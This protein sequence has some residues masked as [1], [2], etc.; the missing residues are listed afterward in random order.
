VSWQVAGTGSAPTTATDFVGQSPLSGVLT[1]VPGQ[2]LT[3]LSIEVAGDNE[4]EW[5]LYLFDIKMEAGK[6]FVD[7]RSVYYNNTLVAVADTVLE[8]NNTILRDVGSGFN[9]LLVKGLDSTKSA[10]S[11]TYTY[12]TFDTSKTS[13]SV[14]YI[15]L[16]PGAGQ[17]FPYSGTLTSAQ[18]K[19]FMIIPKNNYQAQR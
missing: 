14:G 10:N 9:G 5:N 8:S 1:F 2:T 18:E 11:I 6:N 19:E 17:S 12:R 15:T 4:G 7:T 3:T 13:N 16:T